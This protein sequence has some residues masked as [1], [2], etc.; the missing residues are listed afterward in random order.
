MVNGYVN[1]S[2]FI[3]LNVT[4]H[5]YLLLFLSYTQMEYKEFVFILVISYT[6][7]LIIHTLYKVI[8]IQ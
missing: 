8:A 2:E 3:F 1:L 6:V 7:C 4:S 5:L